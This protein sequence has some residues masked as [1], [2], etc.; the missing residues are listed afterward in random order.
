MNA[1]QLPYEICLNIFQQLLTYNYA[2]QDFKNCSLVCKSWSGAAIEMAYRE[3]KLDGTRVY[4]LRK[5]LSQDPTQHPLIKHGQSVHELEIGYDDERELSIVTVVRMWRTFKTVMVKMKK[6]LKIN[7]GRYVWMVPSSH[8]KSWFTYSPSC[9]ISKNWI[10]IIAASL[11]P[12]STF[13]KN[14]S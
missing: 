14:L 3:I 11:F 1:Q 2:K 8:K 7:V 6:S 13:Y 4:K 10:S 5:S 9:A 12:I